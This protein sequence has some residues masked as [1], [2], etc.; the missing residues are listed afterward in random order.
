MTAE[1]R[2]DSQI[3]AEKTTL[4]LDDQVLRPFTFYSHTKEAGWNRFFNFK[5]GYVAGVEEGQHLARFRANVF[6]QRGA[7]AGAF[8]VIPFKILSL[9][10]LGLPPV[11]M[12][13]A[14]S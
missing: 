10:E 14:S 8:R 6:M 2:D 7:V 12:V 1:A 5:A 3:V 11:V 13:S 9:G 4:W